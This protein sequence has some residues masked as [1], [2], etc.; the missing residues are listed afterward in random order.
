MVVPESLVGDFND[1][2]GCRKVVA[3]PGAERVLARLRNPFRGGIV[4][5]PWKPVEAD[6]EEIH[7]TAFEVCRGAAEVVRTQHRSAS[8]L[9]H[10]EAGS[11]KTHLIGRLRCHL[12]GQNVIFISVQLRTSPGRLWRHIRQHVADDLLRESNHGRSQ[13]ARLVARQSVDTATI[14]YDLRT[15]LEHLTLSRHV[16]EAR[17]WLRGEILPESAQARLALATESDEGEH[18]E[19][20]ARDIVLQLCRWIGSSVPLVLCFDQVEALQQQ[21]NDR[22]SLFHFGKVISTLHDG[23]ENVL[24]VCC[25]QSS[26][27]DAFYDACDKADQARLASFDTCSL[28]PLNLDQALRLATAR[29]DADAELADFRDGREQRLWPLNPRDLESWFEVQTGR[30]AVARK[31]IAHCSDRFEIARSGAERPR[32]P[33]DESPLPAAPGLGDFL[34]R[35]W[36]QRQEEAILANDSSQTNGILD[37]GLPFLVDAIGGAWKLEPRSGVRDLDMLFRDSGGRSVGVSLCNERNMTSL[38]GRLRRLLERHRTMQGT[39]L[40]IVRDSRLPISR[41]AAKTREYLAEL[42]ARGARVVHPTTEALAALEAL[43]GM[44]SEAKAGDLSYS[45]DTIEPRTVAEWIVANLSPALQGLLDDIFSAEAGAP[46]P[47]GLL[48]IL[49]ERRVIGLDVV[50]SELGQP[51]PA[52][53]QWVRCNGRQVGV[54]HGPPAVLFQY[55]PEGFPVR[56]DE[57]A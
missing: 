17:A 47:E 12:A 23:T 48:D 56:E 2:P 5:D 3:V 34:N 41:A 18:P 54:L 50:A 11:G 32:L 27:K 52:I 35:S 20:K 10:G 39:G 31:V 15:V 19:D 45:G 51:A 40:V 46:P 7:R 9:L 6:V 26:F 8:V 28:I 49:Q 38:A 1:C 16:Q 21:M 37:Q 36:Q 53:E 44:L 14:D 4:A 30:T 24:L 25:I 29:L 22:E 43:R 33:G 55:V 57:R 13:F 42:R